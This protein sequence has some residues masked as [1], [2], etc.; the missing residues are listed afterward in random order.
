MFSASEALVHIRLPKQTAE[1][2]IVVFLVICSANILDN[3]IDTDIYHEVFA[4]FV[5]EVER[6]TEMLDD[7]ATP[8]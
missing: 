4:Y 1:E 8:I 7:K 6:I 2:W 3:I 5:D